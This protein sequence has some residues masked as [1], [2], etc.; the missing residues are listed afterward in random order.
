MKALWSGIGIVDGRGKLN[1][2]V[3]SSNRGGGYCRT[4]VSPSQPRSARQLT[5][6]SRLSGFA[7]SFRSLTADEISAWN[8]A[9]SQWARTDI[10][11]KV[12]NPTGLDLY[13]RLNARLDDIG[14]AA[15]TTPPTPEG[16]EQVV[17]G[18][19]IMTNGG[20]KTIAYTG[21]TVDSTVQVY[22]TKPLSPGIR[23]YTNEMRRIGTFAGGVASPVDISTMY[24]TKFGEPAVGTRVAVRLVAVN[25]TTGE[26]SLFSESSTITV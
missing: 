15:I 11:G 17:A 23:N 18:A 22:A 6:R 7:Q 13:V 4:K 20:A 16:A 9:V 26:N 3:M 19:L 21:A 24:E 1:G 2:T 10:F 25:E 8:A 12:K 5:V 14:V